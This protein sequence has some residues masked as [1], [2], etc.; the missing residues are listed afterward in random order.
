[1]QPNETITIY[2]I[3]H[4]NMPFAALLALLQRHQIAVLVDVRSAP[5]SQYTPQFNREVLAQDLNAAG[6]DYRFAGAYL[7]GRPTDP[8]CYKTGVVPEGD[9]DFLKIVDYA[10]VAKRD[11]YRRGLDRLIAIA[12]AQR[13]AIMCSEEDPAHCHRQHLIAQTL[14]A[15]QIAVWHIRATG[16]LEAAR[17]ETQQMRLF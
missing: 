3:G 15:R 16:D 9:A 11:W 6:I 5:Y 2:T 8:T 1:M 14:L 7:G 13:T 10:E 4:S 17:N 12:R